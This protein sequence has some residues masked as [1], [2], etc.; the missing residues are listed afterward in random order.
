MDSLR[1]AIVGAGLVTERCHLPV[2]LAHDRTDV[3]ALVDPATDRASRLAKR[4]GIQPMVVPQLDDVIGAIDAAIIASP[5]ATHAPLTIQCLAADVSVLVEKPLATSATEAARVV[6][7]AATSRAVA[8][9]AYDR[10]FLPVVSL[11]KELLDLGDLGTPRR[12][13]HQRGTLGGWSPTSGYNLDAGLSGGG[14]VVIE[15][16]HFLDRMLYWFG[17]PSSVALQDDSLGGPESTAICRFQYVSDVNTMD[18]EARFSKTIDWPDGFVLETTTGIVMMRE[19]EANTIYYREKNRSSIVSLISRVNGHAPK[20]GPLSM[21]RRKELQ[22]ADF[23]AACQGSA[24]PRVKLSDGLRVQKLID[25]LKAHRT[26]VKS[27]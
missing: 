18:G 7:A 26:Y 6:R 27:F 4:F 19:G 10:R 14:V 13:V 17:D 20:S 1:L 25:Q 15:G 12:F 23:I 16:S 8:T 24:T 3:A 21:L 11:M 5:N 2:A 22:W 9:V